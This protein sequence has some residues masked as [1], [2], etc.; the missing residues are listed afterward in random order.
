MKCASVT[1][2]YFCLQFKG[3]RGESAASWVITSL[4]TV[5]FKAD[6]GPRQNLGFQL[7][8]IIICVCCLHIQSVQQTLKVR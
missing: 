7:S 3:G 2:L 6:P 1:R 5:R 4:T 8:D